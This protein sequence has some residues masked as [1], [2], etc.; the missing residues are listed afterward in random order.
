[1]KHPL[2][3]VP[4][5]DPSQTVS[6][7]SRTGRFVAVRPLTH[8]DLIGMLANGRMTIPVVID[9]VVILGTEDD[10][11]VQPLRVTMNL[12]VKKPP[13]LFGLVLGGWLPFPLASRETVLP[14]RN[15]I[16]YIE[17]L[18][19]D[20][21]RNR[22]M[23]VD[24]PQWPYSSLDLAGQSLSA[25]FY[26]FEGKHGRHPTLEAIV[27]DLRQGEAALRRVLPLALVQPATDAQARLLHDLVV[28]GARKYE[29]QKGF[30]IEC[31][32]Q[33]AHPKSASQARKLETALLEA[34][35][36]HRLAPVSMV[37]LAVLSCLYDNAPGQPE[38]VVRRPG[39]GVLK[40]SP[41]Y[42]DASAYNA[43]T[44]LVLLELFAQIH[45][46]IPDRGFVFYTRDVGLAAFWAALAPHDP[47]HARPE[48]TREVSFSLSP[49]LMPG[50]ATDQFSEVVERM[51]AI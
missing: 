36:R 10:P 23:G 16:S 1:M 14:D 13:G 38:G 22:E 20:P 39:R 9:D 42:N 35:K 11:S 19:L 25:S 7:V 3:C 50:L 18:R 30:L 43:I 32:P 31:C 15:V 21:D 40:P 8:A 12:E 4:V 34:A 24:D 5:D 44:D 6:V 47:R 37:V 27:A 28:Q 29:D 2:H 41:D 45:R 49:T 26:A 46:A 33:V 17:Q 51:A 48:D